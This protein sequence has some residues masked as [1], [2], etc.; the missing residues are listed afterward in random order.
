[1]TQQSRRGTRG[2]KLLEPDALQDRF[3]NLLDTQGLHD[4]AE[5]AVRRRYKLDPPTTQTYRF[6]RLI[7]ER[8]RSTDT[9]SVPR[10]LGRRT[11]S[12]PVSTI[13]VVANL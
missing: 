3:G 12:R 4:E 7:G 10:P 8:A 11:R 6:G 9:G 2:P 1:V 5:A 13:D